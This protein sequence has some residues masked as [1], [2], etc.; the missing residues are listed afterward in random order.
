MVPLFL[1]ACNRGYQNGTN[2]LQDKHIER[3][4]E[5][6]LYDNTITERT[7]SFRKR[8]TIITGRKSIIHQKYSQAM[9][10]ALQ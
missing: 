9:L 10:F 2:C 5:K 8:H 7:N 6:G 1:F 3:V 4:K